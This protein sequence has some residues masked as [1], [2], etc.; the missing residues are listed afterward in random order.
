MGIRD[1]NIILVNPLDKAGCV[2]ELQRL[3]F[4][5]ARV[6]YVQSNVVI[7]VIPKQELGDIWP[8]GC[9]VGERGQHGCKDL[10]QEFQLEFS[11]HEWGEGVQHFVG[12]R[13]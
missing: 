9:E 7:V 6:L 12:R 11:L 4:F 8:L 5:K 13:A 10:E 3:C 2:G 1:V